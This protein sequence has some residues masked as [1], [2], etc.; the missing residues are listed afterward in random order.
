MTK[1]IT[2]ILYFLLAIMLVIAVFAFIVV[3]ITVKRSFPTTNGEIRLN[4]VTAPVDIF[5]DEFGIPHIYASTEYD[6]FYAQGY[7]H[8]QDRF[9]QMDFW[10]HQGSG[11]LSEM[12]GETSSGFDKF[13]RTVGWARVAEEE[14]AR[15]DSHMLNFLQAYADGVNA[16]LADH[17]G[18]ALS[19]EYAVLG[20]LTPDYQVEPWEPLHTL[21]WGKAMAWD[22]GGNMDNEIYR[23]LLLKDFTPQRSSPPRIPRTAPLLSQLH[24][25]MPPSMQISTRPPLYTTTKYS[26]RWRT[27]IMNTRQ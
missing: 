19:L 4:G 27:S 21:T 8:A 11:T 13:L 20:L 1:V 26:W 18:S 12:F 22:L 24:K 23:A 10:R 15:A 14:L 7:V 2:Y 6:L 5:R 3:P 25:P 16:Y 17:Q 9:W